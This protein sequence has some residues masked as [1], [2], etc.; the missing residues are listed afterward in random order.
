MGTSKVWAR[1]CQVNAAGGAAVFEVDE[2]A[3][4]Q[5]AVVGEFVEGPAALGPQAREHNA[6]RSEVGV[7]RCSTSMSPAR[8]AASAR[9]S[10]GRSV[11]APEAS[12]ENRLDS[13]QSGC[14]ST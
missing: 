5:T 4:G 8:A 2:G 13:R 14:E 6:Q 9:R 11:V 7:G 3:P 10:P 1:V 12:S